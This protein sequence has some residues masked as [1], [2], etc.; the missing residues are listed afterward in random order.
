[1]KNGKKL[2]LTGATGFIG[3]ALLDRFLAEGWEVVALV[4]TIPQEKKAGV[5][6]HSFDLTAPR[7]EENIFSGVSLFIHAAYLKAGP[8]TDAFRVNTGA[9]QLLYNTADKAGVPHRIFISSLSAQPDALSVYGRQKQAIEQLFKGG[10][11]TIVRPG[12]VLGHGGL[13]ENM[14]KHILANGKIP[15]I[16]GGKQPIQSVHI[17][18]LVEAISRIADKKLTGI[19][20]VAE[21]EAVTYRE[22]YKTLAHSLQRRPR[23][24]YTPYWFVAFALRVA[25]TL[26]IKLPVSKDNLLGLKGTRKAESQ[27][28]LDRLGLRIRNYK[29]SF[30][31]LAR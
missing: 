10:R 6:Y 17:G 14:R 18:D 22:F 25:G 16:R 12:L 7:L 20:T 30:G 9:A 8:G 24:R 11:D 26:G 19:F 21:P 31:D 4:R 1:M 5:T 23:F 2:L 29:E 28:S 15:L 27:S 13:F 3:K